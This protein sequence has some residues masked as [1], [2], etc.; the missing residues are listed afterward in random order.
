MKGLSA[1]TPGP[2]WVSLATLLLAMPAM[3]QAQE[4]AGSALMIESR[5]AAGQLQVGQPVDKN[6]QVQEVRGE[7]GVFMTRDS[8][9]RVLVDGSRRIT[10]IETQDPEVFTT[11]LVRVGR[12][13][14]EDVLV[15]YGSPQR[16]EA[17]NGELNVIYQNIAFAFQFTSSLPLSDSAFKSLLREPVKRMTVARARP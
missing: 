4:K 1:F 14:L 16:L 13:T 17:A 11:R 8:T 9:Y 2:S 15:R 5:L 6:P 3:V 7:R 12:S 10:A